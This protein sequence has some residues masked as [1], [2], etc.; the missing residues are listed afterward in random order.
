V[1]QVR[2]DDSLIHFVIIVNFRTGTAGAIVSLLPALSDSQCFLAS[3]VNKY[4]VICGPELGP[5]S[6]ATTMESERSVEGVLV[7]SSYGTACHRKHKTN[8]KQRIR[9]RSIATAPFERFVSRKAQCALRRRS[10]NRVLDIFSIGLFDSRIQ[11]PRLYD[12]V[13]Y[14]FGKVHW[15]ESFSLVETSVTELQLRRRCTPVSMY[16]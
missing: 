12:K 16:L 3:V 10:T 13:S 9:Y 5:F 14:T 8:E 4:L 7:A 15:P 1:Q 2:P 6:N 11:L